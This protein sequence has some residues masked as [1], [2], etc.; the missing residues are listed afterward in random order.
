MDSH[1]VVGSLFFCRTC[2]TKIRVYLEIAEEIEM[3]EVIEGLANE[4]RLTAL[5]TYWANYNWEKADRKTLLL[6]TSDLKRFKQTVRQYL[7]QYL[8][9]EKY[10]ELRRYYLNN[11]YLINKFNLATYI[12]KEMNFKYV[13]KNE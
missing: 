1:D 13:S 8:D 7:S 6:F 2:N 12:L 10:V 11:K 3:G 4:A 9:Y 5:D